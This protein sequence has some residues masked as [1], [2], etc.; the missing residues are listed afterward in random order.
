VRDD[1]EEGSDGSS[2][3]QPEAPQQNLY[4]RAYA[5]AAAA[6]AASPNADELDEPPPAVAVEKA[7]GTSSF[8]RPLT[9]TEHRERDRLEGPWQC[10]SYELYEWLTPLAEL[11]RGCTQDEMV[12]RTSLAS[13]AG[14][15]L[16]TAHSVVSGSWPRDEFMKGARASLCRPR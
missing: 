14:D 13:K 7:S 16:G 2:G 4:D 12:G 3:R 6:V 11:T 8:G 10:T 9:E 1:D 5:A 15:C